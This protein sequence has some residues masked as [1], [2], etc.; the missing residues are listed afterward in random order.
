MNIK[1]RNN[2]LRHNPLFEGMTDEKIEETIAFYGAGEAHYGKGETLL[3]RDEP[4]NR[5]ALVLTGCVQV[6]SDDVEG[7]RVIMNTVLPGSTFGE[8]LCYRKSAHSPVYAEAFSACTVLWL[9]ADV[10]SGG[11]CEQCGAFMKML[12]GKT[13]AMNDRIQVLSKLTLRKKLLTLFSQY[14]AR[15][16]SEFTLPFDRDTLAEYLGTT[17][18]SLSRELGNM[19]REGLIEVDRAHVKLIMKQ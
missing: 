5:F 11:H 10:F 3:K 6:M 2:V 8:S 9:R 14:A 4:V 17:R 16:G 15:E 18:S 19:V 1:D 12:T 7:N 13:L